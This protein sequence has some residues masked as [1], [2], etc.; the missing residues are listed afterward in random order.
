M[1]LHQNHLLKQV[2]R[3]QIKRVE[4]LYLCNLFQ[5]YVSPGW[6]GYQIQFAQDQRALESLQLRLLLNMSFQGTLLI[7]LSVP[8]RCLCIFIDKLEI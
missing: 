8:P 5:Y 2:K 4:I 3:I 6:I 7:V 1:A